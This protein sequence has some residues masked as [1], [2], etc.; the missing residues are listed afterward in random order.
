MKL[1]LM[2][3]VIVL[4]AIAIPGLSAAA[5]E[6]STD[7]ALAQRCAAVSS[8]DFSKVPEA[9]TQILQTRVVEAKD[10]V[11]AYCVVQGAVTSSVGFELKLPASNWNGKF[12]EAGC[13]NWCGVIYPKACDEPLRRGYACIFTDSGHKAKADDVHMTDASWAYNNLQA[14][15]D[16]GGRASHV[17]AVIGKAITETYYGKAPSKSYFMGCSYGGHQAL[18]LAQRFPWDFDGIVG[19]GAPNSISELMQQNA[20]ALT[21]AFSNWKPVFTEADIKVLHDDVLARCDMDDGVKDRIISNPGACKVHPDAL[22]CKPGKTTQCISQQAADVAKRMYSGPTTS[23][24]QRLVTGGWTPGSEVDWRIVYKPD[25]TSLA[26]LA[27]NYFG[28]MAR[29]PDIGPGWTVRDYD[30]DRDYK[31]NDVMETIYSAANPDLRRF[32]AAGGKLIEYVGWSDL[33]TLPASAIDYYK[34][35]EKTMGGRAATEDFFR[36]FMIP[37][38][39]HCRGGEGPY[40]VDF[41]SY[42][43]AWVEKGKAP[44]VMIGSHPD[45]S[46][47]VTFTRPLYPYPKHAKYKGSGDTKDAKNFGPV[48]PR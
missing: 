19:G 27:P 46:G 11:P 20:W 18:V 37:A 14:K 39:R 47:G 16:W 21:N 26:A 24:G 3:C 31:R 44:D 40:E 34:T 23:T 7:S 32:K 43:E 15:V 30:F 29:I 6:A 36:M 38:A 42:I 28:Y 17:T 33:G 22:V 5:T 4:A 41:L 9:P 1:T 48:T 10:K 2:N 12:F 8:A 13:G 35:T 25:G 45:G